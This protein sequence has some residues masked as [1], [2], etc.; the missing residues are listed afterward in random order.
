MKALQEKFPT[1]KSLYN[2]MLNDGKSTKLKTLGYL[3]PG[4]RYCDLKFLQNIL[5]DKQ[6]YMHQRHGQKFQT[7]P[8]GREL[9]AKVLHAKVLENELLKGYLPSENRVADQRFLWT[10]I[11]NLDEIFSRDL[12]AEVNRNRS[13]SHAMQSKNEFTAV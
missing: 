13:M 9:S 3:L 11:Q 4:I 12:M 2:W 10:L 7:E 1:K 6:S 5:A 8:E